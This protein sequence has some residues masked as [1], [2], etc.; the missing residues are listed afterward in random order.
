[1]LVQMAELAAP[2]LEHAAS[3]LHLDGLTAARVEALCAALELRD[4]YTAR[5]ADEVVRVACE[6]GRRLG[7]ERADV[8][9]L[10]FAARLHD[11]GK[12]ALDNA[13]LHK[14]GPLDRQEWRLVRRHPEWGAS[15]L[16][17][18]QG[19]EA[20][21]A[22]VRFHHERWDGG[23][24][25]DGLMGEQI[26][27]AS[28]I[29]SACDAYRAMVEDRPYRSALSHEEAVS[30]LVRG[31]GRQFDPMVVDALLAVVGGAAPLD[32]AA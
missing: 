15:K 30:E 24:Y 18:I 12:L 4:G 1:M 27:L 10:E 22:I 13:V 9:E 19:L 29:V 16:V 32:S 6:V 25:P 11:I 7:L 5:H 8:V 31:S 28:R 17:D 2:A 23:G 26:P 20:T 14:P 3:G 21:A